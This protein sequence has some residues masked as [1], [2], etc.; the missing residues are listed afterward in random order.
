M[1]TLK[2]LKKEFAIVFRTFGHD[3]DNV[4]REFNK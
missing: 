4:V 1:L 2:K 3:L